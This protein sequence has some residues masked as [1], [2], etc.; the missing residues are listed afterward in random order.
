MPVL[1]PVRRLMSDLRF[2][3]YLSIVILANLAKNR[4]RERSPERRKRMFFSIYPKMIDDQGLDRKYKQSAVPEDLAVSILTDGFHQKV[5]LR[6]YFRLREEISVNGSLV[7]DDW[8]RSRDLLRGVY[9]LVMARLKICFLPKDYHFSGID[10]SVW[11]INEMRCSSSRVARFMALKGCFD[12]F[13]LKVR[14][15]E[16]VYYLHEYPLGRLISWV[17]TVKHP[18]VQRVGFQHGPCAWRKMVYSLS[19]GEVAKP[20]DFRINVA[21]PDRVLAEDEASAMIYHWFGIQEC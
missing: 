6:K 17:L 19:A 13:F 2:L 1:V 5:P 16:F 12:R 8:F 14:T 7:I 18:T 9:W 21:I 11:M 3:S 10:L 4:G 20:A 15:I